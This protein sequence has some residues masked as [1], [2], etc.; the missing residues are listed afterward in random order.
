MNS[1]SPIS[2]LLT[3]AALL[4]LGP[5]AE[6]PLEHG[7][8]IG[9]EDRLDPTGSLR[10]RGTQQSQREVASLI[11][12]LAKESLSESV[13]SLVNYRD[14]PIELLQADTIVPLES[15]A[16]YSRVALGSRRFS[17][18]VE[19]LDAL[20]AGRRES[21]MRR[22]FDDMMKECR[23]AVDRIIAYQ[24]DR[25]RPK[26]RRP[27]LADVLGLSCTLFLAARY[28]N[29]RLACEEIKQAREFTREAVKRA[30][31]DPLPPHLPA[32]FAREMSLP[33]N[34]EGNAVAM[35][36]AQKIRLSK[37]EGVSREDLPNLLALKDSVTKALKRLPSQEAI[38]VVWDA[39]VVE[40]DRLHLS[41]PTGYGLPVTQAGEKVT[42]YG[43]FSKQLVDELFRLVSAAGFLK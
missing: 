9:P 17:R 3:V 12:K 18:L 11:A 36:V 20:P 8:P 14:Y 15:R 19:L 13:S 33:P 6:N 40:T 1:K 34:V 7:E 2:L 4:S 35:A 30:R 22:A 24:K 32:F 39:K 16:V 38:V 41:A 21:H 27:V 29:V 28:G 23:E 26:K 42:V 43:G 5:Y 31:E 37:R 10:S 25:V